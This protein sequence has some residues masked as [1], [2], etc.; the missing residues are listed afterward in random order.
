MAKWRVIADEGDNRRGRVIGPLFD[1]PCALGKNGVIDAP[2]GAEGDGK[3]P[4]GTYPFRRVFYRPDKEE[5]PLTLLPTEPLSPELGW[6]DD[7]ESPHYNK[8]VRLPFGPS[9]EKLW[10]DDEL[11]DLVLVLGHNDDPVVP[12]L[13]SAIFMH[14]AKEGFKPTLG[15]VALEAATLRRFLRLIKPEDVIKIG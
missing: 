5:A 15:C 10:R 6:C 8:L 2:E 3:T 12:G 11:Y 9:H 4:L 14:V 7:P 13:G 1:E